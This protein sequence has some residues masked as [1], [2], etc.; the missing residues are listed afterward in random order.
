MAT[1]PITSVLKLER[2]SF[3]NIAYSRNVNI[4]LSGTEFEM[5]F[6]RQI[7]THADQTHYRVALTAHVWLKEDKSI[8]L[9]VTLVGFF[10]CECEDEALKTSLVNNNT[11][12]ILFPYLRSQI[13][14]ITTQPDMQPV[15]IPPMNIVSMFQEAES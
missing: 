15:I 7:D 13:S 1:E 10:S 11:I 9:T 3:E 2:L 6:T 12:A 8:D 4:P 5:N 14:L